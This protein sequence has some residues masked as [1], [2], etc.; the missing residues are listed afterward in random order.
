M[1]TATRAL[2]LFLSLEACASDKPAMRSTLSP[3]EVDRWLKGV[4]AVEVTTADGRVLRRVS[5]PTTMR[6]FVSVLPQ[7]EFDDIF[8]ESGDVEYRVRFIGPAY[9]DDAHHIW[10][11]KTHVRYVPKGA[12]TLRPGDRGKLLGVLGVSVE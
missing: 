9:S 5:D 10:F 2:L 3:S 8:N 12:A 7:S 1:T 4:E 6:A 11:S